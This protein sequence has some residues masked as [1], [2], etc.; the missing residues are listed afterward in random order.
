VPINF[1]DFQP[2]GEEWQPTFLGAMPSYL[3]KAQDTR[4]EQDPFAFPGMS[5][6]SLNPFSYMDTHTSGF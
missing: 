6:P 3:E 5:D 2:T 4:R 1:D